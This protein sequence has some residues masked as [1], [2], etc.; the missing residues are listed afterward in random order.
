MY[1][2]INNS[3]VVIVRGLLNVAYDLPPKLAFTFFI[4][5]LSI[6]IFLNIFTKLSFVKVSF[7]R[8]NILEYIVISISYIGIHNFRTQHVDNESIYFKSDNI[9]ITR[10]DCSLYIVS[11]FIFFKNNNVHHRRSQKKIH[12]IFRLK[13]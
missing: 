3:Y 8:L 9:D 5:L 1:V 7:E 6:V 13:T 11:Q 12:S 2:Y 10:L 4:R